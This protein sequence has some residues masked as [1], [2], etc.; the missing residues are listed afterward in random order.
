MTFKKQ[1]AIMIGNAALGLIT[2]Y[3]YLFFWVSFSF[4]SSM[5][6]MEALASTIIPLTIAGVY[7]ALIIRKDEK[8]GWIY[9]VATY[10]GTIVLFMIIFV[11][12]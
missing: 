10:V 11:L 2:C 9:A 3:L 1:A 4:S 12:F 8:M 7:N 5:L 6:T